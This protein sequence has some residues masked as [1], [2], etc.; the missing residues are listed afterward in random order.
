MVWKIYKGN[1]VSEVQSHDD[2]TLFIK[3]SALGGV[4]TL[5]VYVD[6]IIISENDLKEM[7]DFQKFLAKEFEIKDLR[8][9]KYF[10]G[11]I[12]SQEREFLFHGQKMSL[13]Y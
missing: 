9:L 10:L 6:D 1:T 3:H 4:T 13:I 2:H 8:K 7:E 12:S 11:I 5:I